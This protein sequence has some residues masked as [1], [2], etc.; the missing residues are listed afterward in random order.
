MKKTIY[1]QVKEVLAKY[2]L[3]HKV[4][5]EDIWINKRHIHDIYI[6]YIVIYEK[7][8]HPEKDQIGWILFNNSYDKYG[9]CWISDWSWNEHPYNQEID[10][11]TSK[12]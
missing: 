3:K 7:G 4:T 10:G 8:K 1:T 2:N 5:S 11:L 12:L 9:D 6:G